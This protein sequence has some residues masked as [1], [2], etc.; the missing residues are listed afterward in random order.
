[1]HLKIG[2]LIKLNNRQRQ[3]FLPYIKP[4]IQEPNLVLNDGGILFIK[5][6]IGE[7]K[8]RY[9]MSVAKDYNGEWIFS[10]HKERAKRY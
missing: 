6:F 7:D 2:S 5:E 8:S 3:E 1:M 10:T 4:T 9:F